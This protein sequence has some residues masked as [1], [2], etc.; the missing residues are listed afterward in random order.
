LRADNADQRLTEFGRGI[1]CVD[2]HR[3]GVFDRKQQSLA[4]GR[5]MLEGLLVS[6]RDL[7]GAGVKVS[8]DGPKRSLFDAL[9]IAGTS[10]EQLSSFMPVGT[11]IDADVGIQIERDALY[12][13]YI[14]RQKN[15]V[16]AMRRDS[17]QKISNDINYDDIEGLSN[18]LKLKLKTVLPD[19]LAQAARIDGMTPAGLML[20]S[21]R[22]KK[23]SKARKAS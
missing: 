12:A 23:Q 22:L 16:A 7:N 19:N 8:A 14:D 2:D 21:A 20:I 9:T 4:I 11:K 6:S 5:N 1:G 15:D 17:E 18:E 3:W 10:L 13:H